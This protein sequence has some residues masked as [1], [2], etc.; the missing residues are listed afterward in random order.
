MKSFKDHIANNLKT[1]EARLGY[2]FWC[3]KTALQYREWGVLEV[4]VND[5]K[6]IQFNEQK[7]GPN[8]DVLKT[9]KCEAGSHLYGGI[10][11]RCGIQ[12]GSGYRD[13]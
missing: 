12:E 3:A 5:L 1:D 9:L 2:L 10:C 4:A 13:E 7:S 8:P 11:M 6:Q